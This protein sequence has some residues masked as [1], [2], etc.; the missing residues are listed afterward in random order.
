[1]KRNKTLCKYDF[2]HN[3]LKDTAVCFFIKMLGPEEE[4]K[5]G[6]VTEIEISERATGKQMTD[7]GPPEVWE[8]N[9]KLLKAALAGNKP[10]KGKKGK[11]GK[12]KKKK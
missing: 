8:S 1:M 9:V 6:H 7:P 12:K 11:K 2:K 10:K 5:I 4:D 3:D